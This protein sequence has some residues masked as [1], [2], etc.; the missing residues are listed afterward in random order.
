M[1]ACVFVQL[2]YFNFRGYHWRFCTAAIPA[3]KGGLIICKCGVVKI[4]SVFNKGSMSCEASPHTCFFEPPLEAFTEKDWSLLF[5]WLFWSFVI[6]SPGIG[7]SDLQGFGRSGAFG[8]TF[9]LK[10]TSWPSMISE[11]V[12]PETPAD[13][14]AEKPPVGALKF[15]WSD[16]VRCLTIVSRIHT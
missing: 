9:H 14:L 4:W 8:S 10:S 2:Q 15:D 12:Q 11:A 1:C 6:A 7:A 16:A 3:T 5:L 13:E